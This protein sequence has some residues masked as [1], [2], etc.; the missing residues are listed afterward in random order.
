MINENENWNFE[1]EKKTGYNIAKTLQKGV[2]GATI[3]GLAVAAVEVA[4]NIINGS[5][6][7]ADQKGVAIAVVSIISFA[8]K[9]FL[10]YIKNKNA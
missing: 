1:E 4:P 3:A 9:A 7:E 8:I 10:N 2:E 5:A 6:L